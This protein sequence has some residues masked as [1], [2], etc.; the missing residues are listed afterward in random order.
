MGKGIIIGN[1]GGT[2]SE[3]VTASK[4]D[5]LE[6]KSTITSDS[7]D[8]VVQGTM[9][10]LMANSDMINVMKAYPRV[11]QWG[12]GGVIDSASMGRGLIVA[13]RPE[14]GKS[15]HIDRNNFY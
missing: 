8:E 4:A 9:P 14:D 13:L 7:N 3:D 2:Y 12:M 10:L 15:Y 11:D 5:V 1:T 6:G